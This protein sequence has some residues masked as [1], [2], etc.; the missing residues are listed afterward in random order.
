LKYIERNDFNLSKQ[1]HVQ[2]P[3]ALWIP[4]KIDWINSAL[5][6][7]ESIFCWINLSTDAML[8]TYPIP[9]DS[10][11]EKVLTVG[12]LYV[13]ESPN[14]SEAAK[15]SRRGRPPLPWDRFHLEVAALVKANGLPRKKE[16]AV[17][18]FME[19]FRKEFGIAAS[20]SSIGQKLTPYYDHFIREKTKNP[21][22]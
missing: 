15:P 22:S 19:W 9:E 10:A 18:H 8:S 5:I 6:A 21:P 13:F 20:R 2:I 4:S 11:V 12:D 16:A 3:Q 7:N 1:L 17:H 14:D